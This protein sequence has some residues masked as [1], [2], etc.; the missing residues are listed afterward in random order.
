MSQ[1]F[2]FGVAFSAIVFLM[3]CGS[4]AS[5][6]DGESQEAPAA[7]AS[8][9]PVEPFF[10]E[11]L[12]RMRGGE[13]AAALALFE[14]ALAS[15]NRRAAAAAAAEILG[16]A[17]AS[18]DG[19]GEVD[20]SALAG[21]AQGS[22]ADVLAVLR[23]AGDPL[24]R[25][26]ALELLLNGATYA[27]A[28][29]ALSDWQSARALSGAAPA[30][31]A[32]SAAERAAVD[33]RVAVTRSRWADALRHFRI[34]LDGSPDLFFRHPTLL[35]D[36]GRAFEYTSSGMEGADLFLEWERIAA[37]RSGS[38]RGR[39]FD[40]LVDDGNESL[41]RFQLLFFSGR[42]ARQRGAESISR[43]ER[44][45]PFA[46]QVSPAQS[47]ATIW[48]ILREAVDRSPVETIAYMER[49][50]PLWS[51]DLT[52]LDVMDRLSRQLIIEWRWDLM[53]RALGAVMGRESAITAKFAW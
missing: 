49:L 40:G 2:A 52:F 7:F 37:A 31:L 36:L 13:E 29:R 21:A 35:A 42:I 44:A 46:I 33:G 11:G 10:Y 27:P 3:A 19:L 14:R 18:E 45:L 16:W 26:G 12:L 9:A 43:F 34:V 28:M 23:S 4:C 47:D 39:P 1:R 25:D 53:L 38:W 32:F 17:L 41:I 24:S 50:A 6:G 51:D 15:H 20:F 30:G 8:A 22:W 48:Y 5:A